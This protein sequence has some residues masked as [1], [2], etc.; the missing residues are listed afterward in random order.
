MKSISNCRCTLYQL[1]HKRRKTNHKQCTATSQTSSMLREKMRKIRDNL[2]F[3]YISWWVWRTSLRSR[4]PSYLPLWLLQKHAWSSSLSYSVVWGML[5]SFFS[6]FPISH[7][8]RSPHICFHFQDD[9]TNISFLCTFAVWVSDHLVSY[10][11][12]STS[13]KKLW[14]LSPLI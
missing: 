10:S 3:W 5:P 6:S 11:N 12:L 2:L 14:F 8:C 1:L 7:F 9:W 13:K 4:R